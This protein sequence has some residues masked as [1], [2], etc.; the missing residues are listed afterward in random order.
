MKKIALKLFAFAMAAALLVSGAALAANFDSSALGSLK[1]VETAVS[2]G[3]TIPNLS[4]SVYKVA[5]FVNREKVFELTP[6]F[7]GLFTDVNSMTTAEK[8]SQ[9]AAAAWNYVV[10]KDIAPASRQTTDEKGEA[11]FPSLEVGLYLVS[12]EEG[13]SYGVKELPAPFF[14]QLPITSD[15]GETFIYDVTAAPKTDS[16]SRFTDVTV[17]KVWDDDD[18]KAGKRT[19]AVTVELYADGVLYDT[20][21]LSSGN[22]WTHTWSGLSRM[23]EWT[24]KEINIPAGYTAKTATDGYRISV[25][26]VYGG[27]LPQTGQNNMIIV[28]LAA[29]G[30]I[31]VASGVVFIVKGSRKK[32]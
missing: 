32:R 11:F 31:L 25:I 5:S 26:N 20:V 23:T 29:A 16:E 24:V 10:S 7:S 9:A 3:E 21:A 17:T 6:D 8:Q 30:I 19:D 22:S 28:F 4:V 2:N 12:I 18:N 27:K 1:I 14:A 15:D 13:E